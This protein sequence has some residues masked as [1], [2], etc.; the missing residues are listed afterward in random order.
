MSFKL[1]IIGAGSLVFARTLFTDIMYVPEFRGIDIDFT[2]INAHNLEKVTLLSQHD[3]GAL[4]LY[5][6]T[7]VLMYFVATSNWLITLSGLGLGGVA[8]VIAYKAFPLSLIPISCRPVPIPSSETESVC[9]SET[10]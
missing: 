7:T 2:D 5:F 8:A 10:T 4:L 9:E 3:L 1:A 6:L